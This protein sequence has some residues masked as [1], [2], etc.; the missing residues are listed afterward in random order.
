MAPQFNPALALVYEQQRQSADPNCATLEVARKLV[1]F[2]MAVDKSGK[3]FELRMPKPTTAADPR[4]S[5]PEVLP[6]P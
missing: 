1:A 6:L 2:L 4:L 3:D 5:T